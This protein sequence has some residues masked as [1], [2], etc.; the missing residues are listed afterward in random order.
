MPLGLQPLH[1]VLIAIVALLLFV[2]SYLPKLARATGRS[3]KGIGQGTVDMVTGF[4]DEVSKNEDRTTANQND[5]RT[6]SQCGSS[7]PSS[8]HFCSHCGKKLAD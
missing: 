3:I 8:A 7:S 6:C 1:L 2:P 4:R 5:S